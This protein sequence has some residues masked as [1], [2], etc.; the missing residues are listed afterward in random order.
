MVFSSWPSAFRLSRIFF[1]GFVCS[2]YAGVVVGD[3]FAVN[4][5]V[6]IVRRDLYVTW[7]DGSLVFEGI[8]SVFAA[9]DLDLSE[10][11]LA[12]GF[13]PV[14][15]GVE[16]GIFEDEVIVGFA[17]VEGFVASLLEKLGYCLYIFGQVDH[18]EVLVFGIFGIGAGASVVVDAER[19][20]HCAGDKGTSACRTHRCGYVGSV[21][22]HAGGGHRIEGWGVYYSGAVPA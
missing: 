14:L 21:E 10:P 8:F 11:G 7:R 4:R 22:S 19:G 17:L 9:L 13:V 18:A 6:G 2:Q 15:D 1:Y 3:H 16:I 12:F 20:L 5:M